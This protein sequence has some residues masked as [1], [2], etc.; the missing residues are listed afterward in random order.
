MSGDPARASTSGGAP[1]A[2]RRGDAPDASTGG[3]ARYASRRGDAWT[4]LCLARRLSF[5]RC[6]SRS[7]ALH[8][9]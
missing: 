7:A 4:D 6:H 9:S 1:H 3:G 2:S 5:I 8:P